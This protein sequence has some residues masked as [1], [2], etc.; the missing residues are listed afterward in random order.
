MYARDTCDLPGTELGCVDSVGAGMAEHLALPVAPGHPITL[1]IDGKNGHS[2]SF[3]L[4]S[5]VTPF[6]E[7]E[8]NDSRPQ[9]NSFTE[10]FAAGIYPSLDQDWVK[11]NITQSNATLTAEVADVGNGDC[12][13]HVIDSQIEIIGTDGQTQLAFN[14]DNADDYC[15]TATKSGLAPG[16]YYIRVAASQMYAPTLTFIYRL[17]VMVQ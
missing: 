6:N 11:V 4:Q 2:G 7:I 13:N 3:S 16:I 12:P 10:P 8:P 5:V 17:K 15:S 9:A 14:D 1:F